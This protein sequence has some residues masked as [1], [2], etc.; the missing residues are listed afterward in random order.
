MIGD[1]LRDKH[2]Y[3]TRIALVYVPSKT[4]TEDPRGVPLGHPA[5]QT[6]YGVGDRV[7]K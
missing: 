4:C 6:I 5:S 3:S 1:A 7:L 2:P